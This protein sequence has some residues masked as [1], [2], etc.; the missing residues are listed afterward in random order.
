MTNEKDA[1]IH[2]PDWNWLGRS[3][4]NYKSMHAAEAATRGVGEKLK[5]AKTLTEARKIVFG[6][7]K[8]NTK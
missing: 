7:K 3:L 5:A 6:Y 1:N 2:K 8:R 4:D